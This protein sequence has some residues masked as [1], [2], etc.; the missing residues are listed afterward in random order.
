[1]EIDTLK[2]AIDLKSSLEFLDPAQ[3]VF[4][5]GV[6]LAW[7]FPPRSK[8]MYGEVFHPAVVPQPPSNIILFWFQKINFYPYNFREKPF[9][10]PAINQQ[11]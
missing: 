3:E 8:W 4:G 9:S 5:C 6:Q 1:M 11:Q 10:M 7:G 2:R